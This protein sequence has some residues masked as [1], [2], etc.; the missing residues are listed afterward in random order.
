MPSFATGVMYSETGNNLEGQQTPSFYAT[1]GKR[2]TPCFHHRSTL[3]APGF[4]YLTLA[5]ISTVYVVCALR[6]NVVLLSAL[7]VL[8]VGFCLVAAS[9]FHNAVGNI[10][11]GHNLHI[12]R[13]TDPR[14]IPSVHTNTT[15]NQAAGA[16]VFVI[17]LLI[18]YL[19]IV[20]MLEA[21]DFPITLPVG[22]LSTV[23][24]GKSQRMRRKAEAIANGD[25]E[26][27]EK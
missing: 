12:V 5:I 21:V 10:A 7:V 16:L 11:M 15:Q 3:T 26:D 9:Y 14:S 4:F 6:T 25:S 17:S 22:D 13:P 2:T 27:A 24:P 19:F 18:W 23:V 1:T 8:V 20:Q